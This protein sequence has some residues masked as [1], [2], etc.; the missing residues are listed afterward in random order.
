MGLTTL[1]V[2]LMALYTTL[3]L[4]SPLVLARPG[5]LIAHPVLCLRLWLS[6]FVVASLALTS[7]LGIFIAL[8]LRH[9]VVHVPGHD[10][11][12]PL[13]DQLLGWLAIAVIGVLSFRMGAA[14]Q[15]ARA[16]VTS[17]TGEFAPL[18][19]GSSRVRIGDH[20]VWI[21]DSSVPLLGAR[22]GRVIAT[23]AVLARLSDD[24]LVAVVEHERAHIVLH[25]ARILAIA[26]IAEAIAPSIKAGQGF[27]AAAR[28]TTE[29]IADD[30]AAAICGPAMTASA[31]ELAYP[32]AP[33]VSERVARLRLRT[34]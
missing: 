5:L 21:V 26:N 30:A 31:L 17:M 33:G 28:I 24:Q 23:S 1:G 19:A 11:L 18:L 12:G 10:T 27:A 25:H 14:V 6:T 9:H 34:G 13:V 7:A 16:A 22:S 20:E 29:L 15:D 2:I 8:S 3:T 4:L 32:S